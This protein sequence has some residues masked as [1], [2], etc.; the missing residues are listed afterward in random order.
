MVN[1][2]DAAKTDGVFVQETRTGRFQVETQ[3]AGGKLLADEPVDVGGDG[4]GPNRYELLARVL[5]PARR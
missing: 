3:T 2:S 1:A 4:T 5:A